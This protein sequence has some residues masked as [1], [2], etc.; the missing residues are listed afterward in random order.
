MVTINGD[1]HISF[2]GCKLG[3]NVQTCRPTDMKGSVF[4]FCTNNVNTGSE[5]VSVCYVTELYRS[6]YTCGMQSI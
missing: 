6:T 3:A 5:S 4:S 2:V 1:S